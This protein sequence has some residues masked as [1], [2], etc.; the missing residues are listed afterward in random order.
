MSARSMGR[1]TPSVG[2][3]ADGRGT[4]HLPALLVERQFRLLPTAAGGPFDTG[5]PQL[6]ADLRQALGVDE[7]HDAAPGRDRCPGAYI[8]CTRA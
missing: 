7:V 8:R 1:G 2:A 4:H 6:Q 3:L 5:M